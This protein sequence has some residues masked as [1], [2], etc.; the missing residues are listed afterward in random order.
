M[1]TFF[2]VSGYF[3]LLIFDRYGPR[4]FLA[5]RMQRLVLPFLATLLTV[6]VMQEWFLARF[7]QSQIFS[8]SAGVEHLWFLGY[9]ILYVLAVWVSLGSYDWSRVAVPIL[10]RVVNGR[11][12]LLR[13]YLVFIVAFAVLRF[14]QRELGIGYITFLGFIDSTELINYSLYFIVGLISFRSRIIYLA[15]SRPEPIGSL[16]M[17]TFAA[18]VLSDL[19]RSIGASNA[20]YEIVSQSASFFGAITCI[21]LSRLLFS[22]S[23]RV[24]RFFSDASYTI[25]LFHHALV[26]VFAW[27]L[28]SLAWSP[29]AKFFVVIMLCL[30]T[31]S[32]LHIFLISRVSMLRLFFNGK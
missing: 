14:V 22:E 20:W 2:V 17:A 8:S 29:V 5:L 13:L 12:C 10:E 21:G 31:T 30:V 1:P 18:L 25:Y 28:I 7:V 6:N 9:L 26:I 4:R 16:L 32:C 3:S 19:P 24:S 27:V 15:I 11:F 23:T